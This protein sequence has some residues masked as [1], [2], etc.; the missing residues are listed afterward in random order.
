[1]AEPEVSKQR[2][3]YMPCISVIIPTRDR[4]K[5][6][7]TAVESVLAQT[8]ADFELL[9]VNDGSKPL[10]KFAS[11]RIGIL[12]NDQRGAVLARNLGV[13]SARGELIA[14][15]DDD[16]VWTA[17]DHLIFAEK[18]GADFFFADGVMKFPTGESRSFAH[19][20]DA[21]SLECNNTILI[22]AV[23]Y[24]KSLHATLGN[25]D[26]QLPYYWDWDWYLRVARAGARLQRRALPVVDILV[27]DQNMSGA[28][29]T[30]ARQANLNSFCAKHGLANVVLKGHVDFV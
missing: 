10:Q 4:P 23:C 30:R 5:F 14:F 6:L 27:H 25:F 24:K 3:D 8:H 18:S 21:K 12:E 15:L 19:D 11:S 29:N 2:I 7:A 16:D 1:L 20:A 17:C 28:S 9:I 22:S 26:E 13:K